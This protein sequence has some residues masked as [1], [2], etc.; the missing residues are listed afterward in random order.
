VPHRLWEAG[1]AFESSYGRDDNVGTEHQTD[2]K[3]AA[4]AAKKLLS[5]AVVGCFHTLGGGN[6]NSRSPCLGAHRRVAGTDPEPL[7]L[8]ARGFAA[9]GFWRDRFG[10]ASCE[11]KSGGC[12]AQSGRSPHIL[13]PVNRHGSFASTASRPRDRIWATGGYR[14]RDANSGGRFGA[15]VLKKYGIAWGCRC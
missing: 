9:V 3:S 12:C 14:F 8:V 6:L 2:G 11:T 13:A 10:V 7:V 1:R 5:S 15:I 4:T